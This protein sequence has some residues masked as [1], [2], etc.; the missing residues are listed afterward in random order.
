[1][2]TCSEIFLCS[3][4]YSDSSLKPFGFSSSNEHDVQETLNISWKWRWPPKK[5]LNKKSKHILTRMTLH[6]HP[7]LLVV[8]AELKY[9]SK[10]GI[11]FYV[12]IYFGHCVIFTSI[13]SF[14]LPLWYFQT[15]LNFLM[16]NITTKRES[17][18]MRT[19]FTVENINICILIVFLQNK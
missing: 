19:R 4:V 17:Q 9:L 7:A 12:L 1:M 2:L 11:L 13:W 8:S 18:L 6:P 5:N 10:V 15:F 3:G 16:S 14:S